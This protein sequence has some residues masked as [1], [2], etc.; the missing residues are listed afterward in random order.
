MKRFSECAGRMWRFTLPDRRGTQERWCLRVK[1]RRE[2]AQ[3]LGWGFTATEYEGPAGRGRG[4]Q[5]NWAGSRKRQTHPFIR[6][7]VR[8]LITS[9]QTRG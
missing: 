8:V 6:P 4:V 3:G 9:S 1:G 7:G 2:G 5:G